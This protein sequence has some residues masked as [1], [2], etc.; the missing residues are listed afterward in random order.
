M[1][2]STD[3]GATWSATPI[4]QKSGGT[5]ATAANTTARFIPAA[6]GQWRTETV[7]LSSYVGQRIRLRFVTVNQYGNCIWIDNVRITH[8]PMV[9]WADTGQT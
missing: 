6:A 9:F 5:L 7:S 8:Q 2:I 1:E 4:Y 3:C